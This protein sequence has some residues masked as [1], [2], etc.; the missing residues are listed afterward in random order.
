MDQDRQIPLALDN[1]SPEPPAP[2]GRYGRSAVA[3]VAA[4]AF[5]GIV[6]TALGLLHAGDRPA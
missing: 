2:P 5:G 3:L 6:L 1:A 4:N